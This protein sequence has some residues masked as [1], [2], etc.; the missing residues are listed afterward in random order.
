MS[1]TSQ[2]L[3]S[4]REKAKMKADDRILKL[5]SID[6]RPLNSAGLL[7]T[8]LFKG[9]NNLHAIRDPYTSLWSLRYDTGNLPPALKLKFTGFNKLHDYV[10]N[11]LKGR[12]VKIEKIID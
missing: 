12:N 1:Q 10:T 11:Y 6:G 7:D 5:G 9:E 3:L 4:D 8:R 2:E